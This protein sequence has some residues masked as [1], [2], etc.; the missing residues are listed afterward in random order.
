MLLCKHIEIIS[1]EFIQK[2]NELCLHCAY[3]GDAWPL[4]N[5]FVYVGNRVS[6]ELFN[7]QKAI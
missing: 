6:A 5:A 3:L 7:L 1:F 4:L 2:V